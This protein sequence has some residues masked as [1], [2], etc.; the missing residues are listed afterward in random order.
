MSKKQKRSTF[1][2]SDG[3]NAML[4]SIAQEKTAAVESNVRYRKENAKVDK[5]FDLMEKWGRAWQWVQ[6]SRLLILSLN[7]NNFW[8][9][10]KKGT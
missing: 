4:M 7:S 5:V 2:E 10:N 8:R 9:E 1:P 6:E 3:F